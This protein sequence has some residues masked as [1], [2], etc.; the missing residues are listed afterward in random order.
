MTFRISGLLLACLT[1]IA[2]LPASALDID[3]SEFK[4]GNGLHVVVIPDHRAPVV[5]QMIWYKVGAADEPQGKAGIAHF[6][7]HLLF[8]GTAKYPNGAFSQIVRINGGTENAFTT[9]DYTV[10]HQ[11]IAKQHL[12]LMM[13]LEADRMQNLVLTDANVLPEL[14]VVLE[15]RRERTDNDP[16][17]LL[18]EQMSAAMYTAHPYGKP[19]IGWMSEVLQ[20]KRQDALDF[21]RTHYEPNNAVLIV[22]GDVTAAE[23]EALATKHYGGLKNLAIAEPRRRT[24]EPA[25]IAERRVILTDARAGSPVW[26]RSYLAPAEATANGKE[27]LALQV[28]ADIIG[29]GSRSRLYRALVVEQKIA[30]HAGAWYS[31]DGLDYGSFGFYAAPNQGVELTAIETAIDAVIA[32]VLK[33]GVTEGELDTTRN[34][35]T[36]D[37][38]YMLDNQEALA[39]TIGAALATGRSVKDVLD[40]DRNLAAVTV[41]DVSEAA[42]AVLER[43]NS[44]TG[45]LLPGAEPPITGGVQN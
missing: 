26:Q 21:Y 44:V 6:L 10:Y 17:S 1:F 7:E 36:A 38:I 33:N 30:S 25:P 45:L 14:L 37:S 12:S 5:T 34:R 19:I 43:K 11:R 24:L 16:S 40:W 29:S 42:R 9:Q 32:D 3:V 23:V 4:L 13:E 27:A 22:A 39:R 8:K 20:L 41:K 35:V 15:E 31:G 2:A 18:A 28:L